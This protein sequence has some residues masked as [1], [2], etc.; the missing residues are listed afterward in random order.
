MG[1]LLKRALKAQEAG[2]KI[3]TGDRMFFWQAVEQAKMFTGRGD[4]PVGVME[5]IIK[6]S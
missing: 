1:R 4:V 5:E 3:V 2:A 6:S